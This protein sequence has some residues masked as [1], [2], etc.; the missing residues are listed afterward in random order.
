MWVEQRNVCRIVGQTVAHYIEGFCS[1]DIATKICK[2]VK[3][4]KSL[5]IDL[6]PRIME[7]L[8]VDAAREQ[9]QQVKAAR[10][11]GKS[12]KASETASSHLDTKKRIFG[13]RSPGD[14]LIHSSS[15]KQNNDGP[16]QAESP[17]AQVASTSSSEKRPQDNVIK[18]GQ[19]TK[20]NH[21][22][23]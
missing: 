14:V 15:K 8:R 11:C 23:S 19:K 2:L 5:P 10:S 3:Y 12:P 20:E 6:P 16:S 22:R 9:V 17:P 13:K 7:L 21:R 18:I 1:R 4:I